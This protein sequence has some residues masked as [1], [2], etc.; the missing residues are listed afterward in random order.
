MRRLVWG[1]FT[2]TSILAVAHGALLAWG[3]IPLLSTETISEGFPLVTLGAVAGSAV[4]ALVVTR[5]PRH[6]IGWLFLLGQLGTVLGLVLQAYGRGALGGSYG[7]FGSGQ[8]A[9]WLG[10]HLGSGYA[11]TLLG[12][13]LLLA[14]DG[15]LRSPR[16]RW[17]LAAPLAGLALNAAAIFTVSP[18]ELDAEGATA[19]AQRQAE[20]LGTASIAAIGI[21][22]AAGALS[23]VLRLRRAGHDERR[24]LFWIA[25]PAGGIALSIPVAVTIQNLGG[26]QWLSVA[27]LMTAYAC[28]P[29]CTGI[30]IL[31]FRLYDIDVIVSR[32]IVLTTLTGFVAAGYVLAVVVIGELAGTA[33]EG[34]FWPSLLATTLVA[35]AFQPLRRRVTRFADRVVYGAQAA[36]YEALAA[37]SARLQESRDLTDMLP[38]VAEAVGRSVGATSTEIRFDAPGAAPV[39]ASW[40]QG[41][42]GAPALIVPVTDGGQPLGSVGLTVAPSR[43]LRPAEKRLVEDFAAQ[44]GEAFRRPPLE[45]DLAREVER[46]AEQTE[47]LAASNRRLLAAREEERQRFEAS[48]ARTVLPHLRRLADE[49]ATPASGPVEHGALR[50]GVV[51][52]GIRDTSTALQALRGLT[53]GVFPAQLAH[54]GLATALRTHLEQAG[55]ADALDLGAGIDGTRFDSWVESMAYFCLVELLRDLDEPLRVVLRADAAWLVAEASG[56]GPV[57]A[58]TARHVVDRVAAVGGT[59]RMTAAGSA[60]TARLQIPLGSSGGTEP[61]VAEP[62]GV[63]L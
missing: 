38:R 58:G 9:L 37:F 51:E 52:M 63:E 14:P 47:Q 13:L 40:P 41:S 26:A 23:L 29:I 15:H 36:P 30:A 11:L 55:H 22:L 62:V 8:I 32:G 39:R 57:T 34:A 43:G 56:S 6:R 17:T 28:V 31:R 2:L 45:A 44:L 20:V 33:A 50:L 61:D 48:I 24:Q 53:R 42:A 1:L 4:G 46:L 54:R 10:A 7:S 12:V 60:T 21:G 59:L 3:G 18:R 19:E 27:P 16:W 25:L 49:L 35:L 5:Y